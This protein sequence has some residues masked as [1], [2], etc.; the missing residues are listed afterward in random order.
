MFNYELSF[1]V[2]QMEKWLFIRT[3]PQWTLVMS[4]YTVA[5]PQKSSNGV[6]L[7]DGHLIQI[8]QGSVKNRW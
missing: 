5:I 6:R 4:H 1:R 8:P 7:P 3:F 2:L